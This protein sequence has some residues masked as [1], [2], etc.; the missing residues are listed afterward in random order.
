MKKILLLVVF[1]GTSLISQAQNMIQQ[2]NDA[3]T[4]GN[5]DQAIELY[6]QSL[7]SVGVSA[8]IYYNIGNSYYRLNRIASAILYY[9]RALLLSPGDKDIRFNL[10]IARLKTIDKIEPVEEFFLTDWYNDVKNLFNANEWS[11]I[12][13]ACFILLIACLVLFFFSGKIA[14]KKLGFYSAIVVLAL[15]I[16]INIFAYSQKQKLTDRQTAIIFVQTVTIKSSPDN[17]GTDLFI[18]HE[19]TKVNVSEKVNGWSKIETAAGN[20]GWIRSEQIE[21]I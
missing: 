4:N 8:D 19:G 9:E 3:Y 12:G 15:T 13:V 18:L 2:A 1:I 21:V 10:E 7:D 6:Q 20:V 14:F 17:S 11:G 5:F 16:L